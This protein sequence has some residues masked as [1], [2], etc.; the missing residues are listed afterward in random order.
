MKR[1]NSITRTK[2]IK[3]NRKNPEKGYF[4][5]NFMTFSSAVSKEN[6]PYKV[7]NETFQ[8]YPY[9]WYDLRRFYEIPAYWFLL[10]ILRINEH[11][12]STTKHKVTSITVLITEIL[13]I[14]KLLKEFIKVFI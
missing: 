6:R 7:L 12:I 1:S 13:S 5:I 4:T 9:K 2:T 11:K 3:E 8:I 10:R 14:T